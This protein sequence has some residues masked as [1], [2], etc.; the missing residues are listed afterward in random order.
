MCA[1]SIIEQWSWSASVA[2]SGHGQ[3]SEYPEL[4]LTD[5]RWIGIRTVPT[6]VYGSRTDQASAVAKLIAAH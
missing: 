2:G 5:N 4:I 3:V 1:V 6:A